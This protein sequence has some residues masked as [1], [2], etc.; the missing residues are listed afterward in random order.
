MFSIDSIWQSAN[1]DAEN[2]GWTRALWQRM[3]PYSQRGR[4]Y[5][6]FP[7][8]GEDSDSLVRS[9]YGDNLPRLARIK[10]QY[11]PDNV[12]RFNQNIPSG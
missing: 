12:L 8:L 1:D 11:D 2:I 4:I 5:L 3:L 7:G 9:S 10:R 6:N